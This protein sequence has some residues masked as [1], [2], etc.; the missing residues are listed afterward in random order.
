M[1]H[2]AK[3]KAVIKDLG[4]AANQM[5]R[6]RETKPRLPPTGIYRKGSLSYDELM[7][8][9]FE[10]AKG[11]Y[12]AVAS[13]VGIVK[14]PGIKNRE[15]KELVIETYPQYADKILTQICEDVKKKYHVRLAVIYHFEGSFRVGEILVMVIIIAR[16]RKK[17][18]PAVEETIR[19]YKT[20]P[21]IWKKEVYPGGESKWAKK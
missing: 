6:A 17:L 8:T 2:Q 13:Y 10:V 14:S 1:W 3:K 9:A 18:F 15:V 5:A 21:T 12:G 7:K 4:E 16:D 11:R 19:R 20:E